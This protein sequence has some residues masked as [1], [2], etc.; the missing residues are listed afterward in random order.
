MR[1]TPFHA[2]YFAHELSLRS[3]SDSIQKLA[4]SILNAQVNLCAIYNEV[5]C[6]KE[7]LISSVEARLKQ[8]T[9]KTELF[10]IRWKIK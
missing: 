8:I 7:E 6:K 10:T 4:A 5:D 2:K 3:P 9:T 1:L